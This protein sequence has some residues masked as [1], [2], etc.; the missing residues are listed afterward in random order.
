MSCLQ[1]CRDDE[2]FPFQVLI[3]FSRV[4]NVTGTRNIPMKMMD[5]RGLVYALTWKDPMERHLYLLKSPR[6]CHLAN[7]CIVSDRYNLIIN[8]YL[9]I[10]SCYNIS[11]VLVQD[12]RNGRVITVID[13]RAKLLAQ[14]MA[15]GDADGQKALNALLGG[16][17]S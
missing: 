5:Q 17:K 3:P 9:C 7:L 2:C 11:L 4:F 15:G 8:S 16:G 1:L 14:R 6:L 12:T 10:Y 13:N